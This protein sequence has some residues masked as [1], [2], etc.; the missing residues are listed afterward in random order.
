MQRDFQILFPPFRLDTADQRL[1]RGSNIIGL[2]PKSFDLLLYLLDHAGKLVTKKSLMDAVWRGTH[3]SDAVLRTSVGEVRE[4]LDDLCRTPK[5]IETVHGRGYRFIVQPQRIP[6][7][8]ASAN[9]HVIAA[10][11]V[12]F[13]GETDQFSRTERPGIVGRKG[14]FAQLEHWLRAAMRGERQ[15]NFVVGEPGVGKTTVVESFLASALGPTSARVGYGQCVEHYGPGEAYLPVLEAL[16]RLCRGPSRGQI[17][18]LLEQYAPT[19]LIQMSSLLTTDHVEQLRGRVHGASREQM[20]R[21]LAEALEVITASRLLVLVL[22]DLH[23]VDHSTLELISVLARRREPARL[24]L[25]GTYRPMDP[26]PTG[27]ALRAV[28]QELRLHGCSEQ[29]RLCFLGEDD[30]SEYLRQRFPHTNLPA[31]L[32]KFVHR[33]TEGNALFMVNM[34]EYLVAEGAITL[35]NGQ[36]GLRFGLDKVGFGMPEN[37]REMI[38]KQIDALDVEEQR[39]LEAASVA[40]TEFSAGSVA[41]ALG[42]DIDVIEQRCGSLARRGRLLMQYRDSE[43]PDGTVAA[44][45]GFIHQLY[46]EVLYARVAAGRRARLHQRMGERQEKAFAGQTDTFAGE[47]AVHFEAGRDYWRAVRYLEQAAENALKRHANREA[48]GHLSRALRLLDRLSG[49]A[50]RNRLELS[51]RTTLGPALIATKGYAAPE[52]GSVYIRARELC[53]PVRDTVQLRRALRGLWVFNYMRGE[54]FAARALGEQLLELAE[55]EHDSAV[56]LEAHYALAATQSCIGEFS[57][58]CEHAERAIALYD[59]ASH[60]SHTL[61]YGKD[62]GVFSLLWS[63]MDLWFL[64]HPDLALKRSHDMRILAHQTSHPFSFAI[65]LFMAAV[66]HQL[67]REPLIAQE[68]IAKATAVANEQEFPFLLAWAPI[69]QGWVLVARGNTKEGVD[70]MHRGIAALEAMN[71]GW[72]RPYHLALLADAYGR[73]GRVGDGLEVLRKALAENETTGQRFYDA[74]LYRLQ[75]ELNLC[76]RRHGRNPDKQVIAKDLFKKAIEIGGVA[77]ARSLQLKAAMS[78]VR[79]CHRTGKQNE[80]QGLLVEVYGSFTEGF[81]TVDLREAKSLLGR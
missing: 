9:V 20:L 43:W 80:S 40:G 18:P 13:S 44:G 81:D 55:S 1:W 72:F 21:E 52:V 17:I 51:L 30:V 48:V 5:F 29:L 70:Q 50:E 31:D 62:P 24:L 41:A 38:E 36:W 76:L 26:G 22:E 71:I 23:W 10:P 78:L 25:I 69:L 61:F 35:L 60:R 64:G 28:E 66:L 63:S 53:D 3:V 58:A 75:G 12:S 7:I 42:C 59:P 16:G 33:R 14:E 77:G 49:C 39:M 57:T 34:V 54:L 79:L 73:I 19:W 56:Y 15:I 27:Q 74:E 65:A 45:Y 6:G 67:R 8:E 37:L 68:H 11:A 47:L 2:R 32:A 46:Q 4:A